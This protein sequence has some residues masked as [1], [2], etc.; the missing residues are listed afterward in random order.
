MA[1]PVDNRKL[2]VDAPLDAVF[3]YRRQKDV[4]VYK[5]K[6]GLDAA[7][8]PVGMMGLTAMGLLEDYKAGQDESMGLELYI[9]NIQPAGG[10][11]VHWIVKTE[12]GYSTFPGNN[13]KTITNQEFADMIDYNW[14]I[15][16]GEIKVSL[17]E[18]GVIKHGPHK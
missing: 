18:T 9:P 2:C 5:L 11:S 12:A 7:Q 14:K 8:Y 15:V 6:M 1:K 16:T 17:S 4:W 3:F 13:G 10:R